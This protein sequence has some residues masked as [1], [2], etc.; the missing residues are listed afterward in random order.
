MGV[1]NTICCHLF[2]YIYPPRSTNTSVLLLQLSYHFQ[3]KSLDPE[4]HILHLNNGR[5]WYREV[6][7]SQICCLFSH[8]NQVQFLRIRFLIRV[9][10]FFFLRLIRVYDFEFMDLNLIM[11][12][13]I[14]RNLDFVV[15]E[16]Y[17]ELR[18]RFLE[19][20]R[21]NAFGSE[22]DS[23]VIVWI[24]CSDNEKSGFINLVSR[25]LR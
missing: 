21:V 15:T 17:F 23:V 9:F 19:V 14:M 6:K 11:L 20:I 5:C 12:L 3:I 1:K 7:Q 24:C 10:S 18:I 8:W 13:V 16:F 22:F 2:Y 25:Y 4:T